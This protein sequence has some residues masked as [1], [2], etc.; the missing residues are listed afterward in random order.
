M[1]FYKAMDYGQQ[2]RGL[3]DLI[4]YEG[5]PIILLMNQ[6]PQSLRPSQVFTTDFGVQKIH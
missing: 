1:L 4:D 5:L 2:L 6:I 3:L